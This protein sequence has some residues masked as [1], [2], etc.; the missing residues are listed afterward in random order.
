MIIGGW[1]M[2]A[3]SVALASQFAVW[4]RDG[5]WPRIPLWSVWYSLALP[6]PSAESNG[7]GKILVW[8]FQQPISVICFI[9]GIALFAWGAKFYS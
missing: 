5:E 6:L 9:V 7:A 8:A 4:L 3:G 1:T 2:I